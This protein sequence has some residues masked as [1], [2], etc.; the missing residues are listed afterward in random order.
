[1]RCEKWKKK[2]LAVKK[3]NFMK[4]RKKVLWS[5]KPQITKKIKQTLKNGKK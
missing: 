5:F 3:I 1:M 2:N 4:K